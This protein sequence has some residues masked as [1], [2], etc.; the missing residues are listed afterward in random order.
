MV[1]LQKHFIEKH[2]ERITDFK[3]CLE[4]ND[5]RLLKCKLFLYRLKKGNLSLKQVLE[6]DLYYVITD[7]IFRKSTKSFVKNFIDNK[8]NKYVNEI[9]C[10]LDYKLLIDYIKDAIKYLTDLEKCITTLSWATVNLTHDEHV[11]I[12]LDVFTDITLYEYKYSAAYFFINNTKKNYRNL[13]IDY[14]HDSLTHAHKINNKIKYQFKVLKDNEIN[15]N[16]TEDRSPVNLKDNKN[17]TSNINLEENSRSKNLILKEQDINKII[18]D[19]KSDIIYSIDEINNIKLNQKLLGNKRYQKDNNNFFNENN[20][21]IKNYYDEFY[22]NNKNTN[23]K[24]NSNRDSLQCIMFCYGDELNN[25]ILN[26]QIKP[27]EIINKTFGKITN[28]NNININSNE[29]IIKNLNSDKKLIPVENSNTNNL[30]NEVIKFNN[31]NKDSNKNKNYDDSTPVFS[32]EKNEMNNNENNK[33]YL[34]DCLLRNENQKIEQNNKVINPVNLDKTHYTK[35]SVIHPIPVFTSKIIEKE[36]ID[37]AQINSKND[38]INLKDNTLKDNLD[39][40]DIKKKGKHK[41]RKLAKADFEIINKDSKENVK[42][43]SKE[44]E[45]LQKRI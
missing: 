26:K 43:N 2:P 7:L 23:I 38:N 19:Q 42:D 30:I 14:N 36:I 13:E 32:L 20:K 31:Q 22:N 40:K 21:I 45:Y 24:N 17:L 44:K 9:Y 18:D 3:K 29:K 41:S 8:Y 10:D 25:N 35:D 33:I 16:L 27:K 11:D 1:R 5:Y 39:N 4:P 37:K 6:K 28:D 12:S 34:K 15:K